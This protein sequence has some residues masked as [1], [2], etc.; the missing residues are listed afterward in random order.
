MHH[1]G[2]PLCQFGSSAFLTLS[3]GRAKKASSHAK[4]CRRA[5]PS[6]G[7]E[8]RAYGPPQACPGHRS[9]MGSTRAFSQPVAFPVGERSAS[10]CSTLLPQLD[11]AVSASA[12]APLLGQ[13]Q[14]P[15]RVGSGSDCS[16][17]RGRR[18]HVRPRKAGTLFGDAGWGGPKARAE[19]RRRV[20]AGG[21]EPQEAVVGGP[22][23]HPRSA[24]L[25]WTASA[26]PW[27]SPKRAT[28][29]TGV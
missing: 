4:W 28:S 15:S 21:A 20:G 19:R 18:G 7:R 23:L 11:V 12:V 1:L 26:E 16:V 3:G 14:R 29:T 25:G 27:L 9:P 8:K 22:R 13:G 2:A 6:L 24:W 17:V 5:Q 10:Q